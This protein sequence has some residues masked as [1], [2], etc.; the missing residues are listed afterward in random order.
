[1]QEHAGT[2]VHSPWAGVILRATAGVRE[3]AVD[4]NME[5]GDASVTWE[6]EGRTV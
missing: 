1:M 3:L 6:S 5:A 2:T 4:L